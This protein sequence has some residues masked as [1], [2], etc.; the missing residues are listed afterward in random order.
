MKFYYT[1][2]TTLLKGSLDCHYYLGRHITTKLNDGYA[3]SGTI[4]L[5]YFKKYG[6]VEGETYIKEIIQFCNNNDELNKAEY[7]LIGDKYKTDPMC[8]NLV[9]GGNQP[10]IS[11][12]TRQKHKKPKTEE[13]KRKLSLNH[14]GGHK[15]GTYHPSE[16]TKQKQ[17]EKMLGRH[18][19][20]EHKQKIKR[21]RKN[22]KP[23]AGHHHT[24]ET[25]N[26]MSEYRKHLIWIHLNNEVKRVEDEYVY[27]W[28]DDGWKLGIKDKNIII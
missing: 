25:K 17:R 7:E 9:A 20:D 15:K 1:Y 12:E 27:Y 11:E 28:L 26:K 22:R 18:L 13:H 2:K 19:T 21:K 3:G 8:L 23:F 6:K 5:K 14:K 24:N 10:G 4:L 16:E